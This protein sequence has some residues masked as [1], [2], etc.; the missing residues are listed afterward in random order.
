LQG[1]HIVVSEETLISIN[2]SLENIRQMI[3]ELNIE[4]N[5]IGD[6]LEEDE[7]LRMTRL[8]KTTLYNLRKSGILSQSTIAGKGV[9][10][11]KSELER[12]LNKNE[13]RNTI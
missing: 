1:V 12:V 4:H 7:V 2:Q 6:W 11:R 3:A 8:G 13:R 9:F 5:S 10:Y